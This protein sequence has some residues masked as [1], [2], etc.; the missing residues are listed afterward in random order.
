MPACPACGV[1]LPIPSQTKGEL[2]CTDCEEA[3]QAC[4]SCEAGWLV[5]RRGRYGVFLGC[6]RFPDCAGKAKLMK[7]A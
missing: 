7:R 2:V 4:V 1:G 6:V 5:E 3:Q